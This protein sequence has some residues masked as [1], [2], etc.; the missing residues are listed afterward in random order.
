MRK[1]GEPRKEEKLKGKTMRSESNERKG[2]GKI[3]CCEWTHHM[4]EAL[5]S[6]CKL[7][8]VSHAVFALSP[9]SKSS[10]GP[11]KE[12]P[13]PIPRWDGGVLGSYLAFFHVAWF[14]ANAVTL[15][16]L[17]QGDHAGMRMGFFQKAGPCRWR[18]TDSAIRE[19][20]TIGGGVS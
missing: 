11:R 6:K 19:E 7:I 9:A 13:G 14:S 8:T 2:D 4:S 1:K 10:K 15:V 16:D 20:E 12:R 17:I 18:L 3:H 5:E